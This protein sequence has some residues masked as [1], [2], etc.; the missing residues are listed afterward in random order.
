MAIYKLS[1]KEEIR[2]VIEDCF[3]VKSLI[4]ECDY[5][6]GY[7]KAKAS[8]CNH[9]ADGE[10][11][12]VDHCIENYNIENNGVKAYRD[13]AKKA[14]EAY[15]T[16]TGYVKSLPS[17]IDKIIERELAEPTVIYY[18]E[19]AEQTAPEYD[20]A[21]NHIDKYMELFTYRW[22]PL[23]NAKE[24]TTLYKTDMALPPDLCPSYL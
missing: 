1:S 6:R 3:C 12:M 4:R 8:S 21:P 18:D 24:V 17:R 15:D 23:L 20:V 7:F 16:I 14:H 19:L 13:E 9:A 2:E 11:G 5:M 10:E 22:K